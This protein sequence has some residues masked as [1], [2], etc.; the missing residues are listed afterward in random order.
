MNDNEKV[1]KTMNSV[2]IT[3]LVMGII[4]VIMAIGVGVTMIV[5]GA[6]L[7]KAKASIMF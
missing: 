1:Y 5:S 7:I 2:G 4:L 3:S 6:K